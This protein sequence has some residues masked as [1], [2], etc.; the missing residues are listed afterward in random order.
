MSILM[1][2]NNIF[3]LLSLS[4]LMCD[5]YMGYKIIPEFMTN[6]GVRLICGFDLYAGNYGSNRNDMIVHSD[7]FMIVKHHCCFSHNEN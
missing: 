2:N 5:L 3:C 7:S 1:K 6:V 4:I